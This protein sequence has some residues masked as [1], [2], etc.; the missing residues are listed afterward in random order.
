M[1]NIGFVNVAFVPLESYKKN[2]LAKSFA[3]VIS[4][5]VVKAE[6]CYVYSAFAALIVGIDQ[7]QGSP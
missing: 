4:K 2:D 1:L 3:E 5:K 7:I 6:F